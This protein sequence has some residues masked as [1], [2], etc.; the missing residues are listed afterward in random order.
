MLNRKL[1][2][3]LGPGQRR[4]EPIDSTGE[5]ILRLV[6]DFLTLQDL[7]DAR[8]SVQNLLGEDEVAELLDIEVRLGPL[9]LEQVGPLRAC[10]REGL[11]P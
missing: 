10:G 1:L 8:L 6:E 7:Q 11:D 9:L 3:P 4:L 5:V 2:Q